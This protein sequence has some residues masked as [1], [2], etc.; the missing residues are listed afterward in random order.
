MRLRV[1]LAGF[2]GAHRAHLFELAFGRVDSVLT[3]DD[4]CMKGRYM[5]MQ[6]D[7]LVCGESKQYVND[8]GG[9]VDIEYRQP[10]VLNVR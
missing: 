5:P 1:S 10:Y 4:E 2:I 3:F 8:L 7:F 9:L 6:D